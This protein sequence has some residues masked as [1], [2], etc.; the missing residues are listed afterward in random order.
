MDTIH[1]ALVYSQKLIVCYMERGITLMKKDKN[2]TTLSFF[3]LWGGTCS[4]CMPELRPASQAGPK[5]NCRDG[6]SV[7]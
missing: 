5:R 1:K 3:L 2:E 4:L 7:V 6:T